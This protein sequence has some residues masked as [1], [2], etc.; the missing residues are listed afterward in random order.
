MLVF[1]T[2]SSTAVTIHTVTSKATVTFNYSSPTSCFCPRRPQTSFHFFILQEP[3]CSQETMASTS[4]LLVPPVKSFEEVI[5]GAITG[6]CSTL[7][8]SHFKSLFTVK[9]WG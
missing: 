9:Q 6:I 8:D 5:R 2:C 4:N 1:L 3:K 7:M